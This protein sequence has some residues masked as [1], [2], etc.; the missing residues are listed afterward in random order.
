MG[1]AD[2]ITLD[3][4]DN[5]TDIPDVEVEEPDEEEVAIDSTLMTPVRQWT[6]GRSRSLIYI[7]CDESMYVDFLTQY[8]VKFDDKMFGPIYSANEF[9]MA[10]ATFDDSERTA[11]VASTDA[12]SFYDSA[13]LVALVDVKIWTRVSNER[14]FRRN[15]GHAG[16]VMIEILEFAKHIM[17]LPEFGGKLFV[18]GSSLNPYYYLTPTNLYVSNVLYSVC[19]DTLGVM[20]EKDK[21]QLR[22]VLTSIDKS[23]LNVICAGIIATI[24]GAQKSD[25]VDKLHNFLVFEYKIIG[26][27]KKPSVIYP[28]NK[29]YPNKSGPLVDGR[30]KEF[31]KAT[32]NLVWDKN[33]YDQYPSTVNADQFRGFLGQARKNM[34][35]R[36][37]LW[38]LLDE[39]Y[40]PDGR[41][42]RKGAFLPMKHGGKSDVGRQA[43]VA[44]PIEKKVV[45]A[46]ESEVGKG[47]GKVVV[48]D[49]PVSVPKSIP[50]AI[51]DEIGKLST[52]VLG[53]ITKKSY[54]EVAQTKPKKQK[55]VKTNKQA[56]PEKKSTI[57][58]DID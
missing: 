5:P 34:R 42:R 7:V 18:Y 2:Q 49:E 33:T 23:I 17:Y 41:I 56:E 36:D 44:G 27:F 55:A 48:G 16:E 4:L 38:K 8:T 31:V 11:I 54:V 58:E 35:N 29:K 26:G 28:V 57:M 53:T 21:E 39:L 9:P 46:R 3:D 24:P 50:A 32:R 43:D 37:N 52:K 30:W 15:G 45:K 6:I 40:V 12:P 19:L 47:K 1:D 51:Q 20:E 25:A 10:W 13:A 14:Y 22:T